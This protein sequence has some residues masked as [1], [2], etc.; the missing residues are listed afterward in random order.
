MKE[1]VHFFS[2]ING[3]YSEQYLPIFLHKES[4]LPSIEEDECNVTAEQ[5]ECSNKSVLEKIDWPRVKQQYK[6][7]IGAVSIHLFVC[8]CCVYILPI[9]ND[10]Y[11]TA[12]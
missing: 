5:L 3:V 11:L 2:S 12:V 10:I 1:S 6:D 9:D 7:L 8:L 4:D